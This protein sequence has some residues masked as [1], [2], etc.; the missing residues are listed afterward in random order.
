MTASSRLCLLVRV[1]VEDVLRTVRSLRRQGMERVMLVLTRVDDQSLL[2]ALEAGVSG[3]LRRQE[4][5]AAN[6]ISAIRATAAGDGTLPPDLVSNAEFYSKMKM[7][8][9]LSV[10]ESIQDSDLQLASSSKELPPAD[11]TPSTEDGQGQ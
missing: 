8:E 11:E 5:S 1:L 9:K 2:A 3:L 6:L 7:I 10:I 4:V